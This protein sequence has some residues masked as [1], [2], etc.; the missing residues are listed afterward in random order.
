MRPRPSESRANTSGVACDATRAAADAAISANARAPRS[1][2][3]EENRGEVAR[4]EN[5]R[6]GGRWRV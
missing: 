6:F 3:F 5:A 1:A 4:E 2:A